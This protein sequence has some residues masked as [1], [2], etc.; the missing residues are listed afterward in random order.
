MRMRA[1]PRR[2][3]SSFWGRPP[4]D[5]R[6][7]NART[8]AGG[9]GILE[10]WEIMVRRQPGG[11]LHRSGRTGCDARDAS[12]LPRAIASERTK[13]IWRAGTSIA[14]APMVTGKQLVTGPLYWLRWASIILLYNRDHLRHRRA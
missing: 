10:H 4:H 12:F 1:L 13:L 11:L 2:C 6:L 3:G 9:R 14:L 5:Y 7:N 8:D